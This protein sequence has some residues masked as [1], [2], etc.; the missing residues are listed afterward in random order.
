MPRHRHKRKIGKGWSDFVSKAKNFL[1]KTKLLSTVG[2]QLNKTFVPQSYRGIGNSVVNYVK[3][4]GYGRRRV[5]R[6]RR[7]KG[8]GCCGG[9][10]R[11]VGGA[12]KQYAGSL[13]PI[14]MGRKRR[15]VR[16]GRRPVRKVNLPRRQVATF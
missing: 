16:K 1:K 7:I 4:Q 6:R 11:P 5:R 13:N 15:V 10:L 8:R 2:S 14:G 12:R 3:K 9:S